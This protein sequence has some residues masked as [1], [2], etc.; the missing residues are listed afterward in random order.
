MLIDT[1]IIQIM[2]LDTLARTLQKHWM[3]SLAHFVNAL[4]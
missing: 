3:T 4:G 1:D 2:M